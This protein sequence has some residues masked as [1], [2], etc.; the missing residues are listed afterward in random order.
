[1]NLPVSIVGVNISKTGRYT[2][3]ITVS[4]AANSQYSF[5]ISPSSLWL[6]EVS[7]VTYFITPPDVL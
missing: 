3:L 7:F 5:T 4:T 2:I 1:H 6:Y